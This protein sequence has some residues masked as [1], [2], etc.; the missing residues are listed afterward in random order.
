M[1]LKSSPSTIRYFQHWEKLNEFNKRRRQTREYQAKRFATKSRKFAKV[2]T[3]EFTYK[4]KEKEKKK[5]AAAEKKRAKQ[6]LDLETKP[7]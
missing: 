4:Q 3:A 1:G 6:Q 7:V 2:E 5:E